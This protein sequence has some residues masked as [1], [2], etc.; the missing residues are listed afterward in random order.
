[1]SEVTGTANSWEILVDDQRRFSARPTVE[2]QLADDPRPENVNL[3][4]GEAFWLADYFATEEF[5]SLADDMVSQL[6]LGQR[7][8]DKKRKLARCII[9]NLV[10]GRQTRKAVADSRSTVTNRPRIRMWDEL[11][12]AGLARCC[13]GS[14]QSRKSTRYE[15]TDTL[16]NPFR[17]MTATQLID[18][19]LERNTRLGDNPTRHALVIINNKD[20]AEEWGSVLP[21]PR[22]FYEHVATIEDR[23]EAINR[24]NA[25]YAWRTKWNGMSQQALVCYQQ[26]HSRKIF[27]FGRVYTFSP[28]SAQLLSKEQRRGLVI[29]REPS[30]EWDYSCHH[31]RMY[32]HSLRLDPQGDLYRADKIIPNFWRRADEADRAIARDIVKRATQAVLN[33]DSR[34]EA[35]GA[36]QHKVLKGYADRIR[37]MREIRAVENLRLWHFVARIEDAHLLLRKFLYNDYAAVAQ[38]I[39]GSMALKVMRRFAEL[40]KPC[41]AI[42]DSFR[43]RQSDS[44]FCQQVMREVYREFMDFECVL[45][46]E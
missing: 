17:H 30:L 10:M 27:R 46:R 24:C 5:D 7:N 44:D 25:D 8:R 6:D 9:H 3:R 37:V 18:T 26:I 11:I 19:R 40:D 2:R 14:E 20:K 28:Y 34:K 42:H 4:D 12:S 31:L 36:L 1:M 22:E 35:V 33:A 13:I 39:D 15:A 16:F 45:S 38:S 21:I 32:Y 43:V 23:I 41:L 29:D